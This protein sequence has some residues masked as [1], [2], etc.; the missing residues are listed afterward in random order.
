MGLKGLK[1]PSDAVVSAKVNNVL[2]SKQSSVKRQILAYFK[3]VPEMIKIAG[4][5]S[6]FRQFDDDGNVVVSPTNDFGLFQ[7]NFETWNEKAK[8]L[9]LDYKNKIEDNMKMARYIYE[10]SGLNSWVCYKKNS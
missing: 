9:K 6:G 10:N 1:L 7:I 8:E 2:S 5:E 4:C 3:D